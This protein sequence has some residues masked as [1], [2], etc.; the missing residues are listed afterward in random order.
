MKR[1]FIACVVYSLEM[2]WLLLG[3][4][5]WLFFDG[6]F[7]IKESAIGE[8][9][10]IV[11]LIP[12]GLLAYFSQKAFTIIPKIRQTRFKKK[13]ELCTLYIANLFYLLLFGIL[14]MVVLLMGEYGKTTNRDIFGIVYLSV[15]CLIPGIILFFAQI[16]FNEAFGEKSE[17]G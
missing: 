9:V 7:T 15:G 14:S 11:I 12:F 6:W 10:K 2:V 17:E 1:Y 3:I 16:S 5:A 8:G 13:N 4:L